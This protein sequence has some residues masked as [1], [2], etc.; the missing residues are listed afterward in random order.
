MKKNS[1][2]SLILFFLGRSII[3]QTQIPI[4]PIIEGTTFNLMIQNGTSELYPGIKTKRSA[5]MGTNSVRH[6]W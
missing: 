5:T 3:A 6:S 2:F 4:P 1:I